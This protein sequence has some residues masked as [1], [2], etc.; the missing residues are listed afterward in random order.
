MRVFSRLFLPLLL[1]GY[2]AIETYLKVQHSSL[3]GKVGCKLAGELLN[4]DPIY[5]NYAGLAGLF[6]LMILGYLSLKSKFFETLFFMGIY[7]AIAFEATILSYQFIA[8]PEPCIFC[9]GIFSSLLLIALFSQVKSFPMVLASVIAIFIGLSTLSISKN[10][11]F[12]EVPGT[13][14]IQSKTCSHCKKVKTYFAAH[15]IPY[16]PISVKEASARNFLKFSG[17]TSIPALIIKEN[18]GMTLLHGDQK[19]I[20]YFEEKTQTETPEREEESETSISSDPLEITSDFLSAGG[21]S[22]GCALTITETAS[23]DDDNTSHQEP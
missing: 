14:L 15:N 8:N 12:I 16:T 1:L 9:L 19:I 22:D 2:M 23:C 20:A 4:F 18:T 13:Y 10:K 21:A 11:T 6:L 3:C 5:L 7:A 17:I